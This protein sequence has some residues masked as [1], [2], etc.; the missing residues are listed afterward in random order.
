MA[1]TAAFERDQVLTEAMTLFW[2]RGYNRTS[3][4]DLTQATRLNPGS[5]YAAFGNKQGLFLESVDLYTRA[6]RRETEATLG[7]EGNAAA[8][9][10][11]FFDNLLDASAHDP[12]NKG[13]LLINTLIEAPA[14]EPELRR[15]AGEALKYV[16]GRF[17]EVLDEGQDDGSIQTATPPR[18]QARLL[19]TGIFGL[20][21]Y[22]RMPEGREHAVEIVDTLL[23]GVIQAG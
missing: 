6:L 1:R 18:H 22:A 2:S 15:R 13:C 19:M 21:V 9:I 8:R 16:E 4:R 11:R 10:R 12:T 3:M 23:Q 5:L 7:G 20:R 14:D 17:A